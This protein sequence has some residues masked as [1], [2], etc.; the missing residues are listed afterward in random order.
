MRLPGAG[1]LLPA[2]LIGVKTGS[3]PL[4]SRPTRGSRTSTSTS[5]AS[6]R[7]ELL[8]HLGALDVVAGKQNVIF[9]VLRA[10]EG[11]QLSAPV[12]N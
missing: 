3:E 10:P 8:A 6:V 5:S 1:S 4:G 12:E 11:L 7:K 9:L 2:N